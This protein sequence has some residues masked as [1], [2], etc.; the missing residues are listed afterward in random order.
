MNYISQGT[1]FVIIPSRS[2]H[3]QVAKLPHTFSKLGRSN[4][5]KNISKTINK[6]ALI[7]NLGHIFS[8]NDDAIK[9]CVKFSFKL[10]F[11]M[12]TYV[13]NG[14]DCTINKKQRTQCPF[15]QILCHANKLF[16]KRITIGVNYCI[17]AI[18][19]FNFH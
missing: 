10:C 11:A 15:P 12:E 4:H 7:L 19:A 14:C 6:L 16:V 5:F 9:N 18:A 8:V 2:T 17:A 3:Q 1:L 13:K